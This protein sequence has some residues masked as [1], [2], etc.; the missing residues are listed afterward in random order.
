MW[1]N[2]RDESRKKEMAQMEE[3]EAE[4]AKGLGENVEGEEGCGENV[5]GAG[6]DDNE[7]RSGYKRRNDEG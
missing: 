5:E 7:E 3:A 2:I 1:G 4:G 6:K